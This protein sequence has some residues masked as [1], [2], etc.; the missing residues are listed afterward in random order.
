VISSGVNASAGPVTRCPGAG[1]FYDKFGPLTQGSTMRRIR[2][3]RS[4]LSLRI[5]SAVRG[6]LTNS[7]LAPDVGAYRN[8]DSESNLHFL[9]AIEGVNLS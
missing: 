2:H 1:V 3:E 4:N 9:S 7:G 5:V 6:L 8:V